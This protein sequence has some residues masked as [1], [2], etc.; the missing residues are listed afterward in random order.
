MIEATIGE[1]LMCSV[2][3]TLLKSINWNYVNA[4][5]T[6]CCLFWQKGDCEWCP[7]RVADSIGRCNT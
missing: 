2:R 4:P 3:A 7:L 1:E 6:A 5:Q